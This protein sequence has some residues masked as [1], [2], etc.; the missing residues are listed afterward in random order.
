L[1]SIQDI[2]TA[3]KFY[4]LAGA[5][6]DQGMIFFWIFKKYIKK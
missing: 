3:L 4:A 5:S 1:R 6:I 2:D